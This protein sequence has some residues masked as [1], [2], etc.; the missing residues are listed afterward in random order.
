M[1]SRFEARLIKNSSQVFSRTSGV[2]I[3]LSISAPGI[4]HAELTDYR[5]L[6][7]HE[8]D[9][10]GRSKHDIL[11]FYTRRGITANTTSSR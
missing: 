10:R 6:R 2:P 4:F 11:V 9:Q 3:T 5:V 1:K 8:A 7:R